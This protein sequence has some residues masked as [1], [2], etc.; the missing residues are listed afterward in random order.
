MIKVSKLRICFLSSTTIIG[1]L[2]FTAIFSDASD[3]S[4]AAAT[5]QWSCYTSEAEFYDWV[6]E[7]VWCESRSLF[8]RNLDAT[9]DALVSSEQDCNVS[10]DIEILDVECAE[11][12]PE[13]QRRAAIYN[14]IR[15]A[16]RARLP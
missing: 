9:Y 1:G 15:D 10:W 4:K 7:S 16:Y 11:K 8:G 3:L 6:E 14:T 5:F 13:A 2:L 12:P